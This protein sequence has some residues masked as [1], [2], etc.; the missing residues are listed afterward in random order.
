MLF[1]DQLILQQ[2]VLEVQFEHLL[3]VFLENRVE[4]VGED[5]LLNQ[6][7]LLVRGFLLLQRLELFLCV[8]L[9]SLDEHVPIALFLV[10]F[11]L[12]RCKEVVKQRYFNHVL[13]RYHV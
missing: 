2:L 3:V 9:S 5:E 11:A 6:L 7:L 4:H 8:F 10:V 12:M 13:L 1:L